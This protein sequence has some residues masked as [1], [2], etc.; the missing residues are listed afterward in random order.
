[1]F[2]FTLV[3]ILGE[4]GAHGPPPGVGVW[5]GTLL[6]HS[7]NGQ[8]PSQARL[9]TLHGH[10]RTQAHFTPGQCVQHWRITRSNGPVLEGTLFL[11]RSQRQNSAIVSSLDAQFSRVKPNYF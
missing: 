5:V 10:T 6:Q 11:G 3:L 1:M 7:T 4:E 9:V 2:R 8:P